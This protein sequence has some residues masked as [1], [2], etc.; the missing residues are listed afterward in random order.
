MMYCVI[1]V[2]INQLTPWPWI[3]YL[4]VNALLHEQVGTYMQMDAILCVSCTSGDGMLGLFYIEC[5]D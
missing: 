1:C 3:V 4:L 2:S 5:V